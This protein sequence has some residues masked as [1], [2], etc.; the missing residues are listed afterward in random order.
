MEKSLGVEIGLGGFK[1]GE[2]INTA[3]QYSI[4]AANEMGRLT[5]VSFLFFAKIEPFSTF[6][7]DCHECRR[8][9]DG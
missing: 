7:C 6:G 9:C 8:I 5:M 1:I 2:M 3:Q 4:I